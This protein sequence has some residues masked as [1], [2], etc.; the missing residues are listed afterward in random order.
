MAIDAEIGSVG[1]G[2]DQLGESGFSATGLSHEQNWLPIVDGL[3]GEGSH[4]F[5]TIVHLDVYTGLGYPLL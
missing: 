3:D 5:E 2:C 4:S 1:K